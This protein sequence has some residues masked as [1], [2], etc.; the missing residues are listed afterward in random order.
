[1]IKTSK[2]LNLPISGTPAPII[3]DTPNVTS[4][5]LLANDF[6]G[7]KPTMM[8]KVGDIVKRGTK[9]FEDKKNP[10]I[11]F[12]SPAGGTVKDINR[13]DKRKFL[14]VE[15]E[16]SEN[17]DAEYFE[18]ENT[19]EGLTELLI[20]TGLWNAFRTRPFNRT[21]KVGSLPDAVFVNACDTNPL[22]VDPYFIIDQDRDDFKNGLEA[23][24]RLFSCPIHCTYQNNNFEINVDKINYCQV[25]GPHPAGLSSTHISQ[26]YPV[27]I[28]KIAWTINYQDIISL[29]YLLKNKSLRTHKI[30]ALGG[31]SVFKP[32]LI[33]ARISGNIDQL[34][35][36]K[37]D[38]NSRVVS[39]SLIY[40]H[41]SEGIMNYLGFYDSII[42]AIPD[43]AN[44]I[45]LNWLMP[46]S[47]LHSKLNV[48]L[49]SLLK[50]NKFTFN[51][52]LNGGDRAIV[53]VGSYDEILPMDIL[54]P[55]L[56]KALVV[57][58]IEQAVELGML[59]LA[60]EDLA[61]ASYICPSKYDYCSILANNLNNLYLE[62]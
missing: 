54:V 11:F 5:S 15:V 21:P 55:Q 51:V 40:G 31:P 47:N 43:E 2:G 6:V 20:N 60:P 18:Y 35:A 33:S 46:G 62:Q 17:E 36:G 1:V 61:L 53:P 29:G 50:P 12:T 9:L 39:G 58:D 24:T 52:S 28:N 14:S 49:S 4:V 30:I 56:L 27:S 59:E 7:M 42:S 57:G 41:A 32:S 34:T 37:I 44:D 19:S 38:N 16:V 45:F 25:S 3:S 48:F 13:G 26:L 23:L 8:V 10:G 22:S